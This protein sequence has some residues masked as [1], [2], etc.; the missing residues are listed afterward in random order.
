MAPLA[1]EVLLLSTALLLQ[2]ELTTISYG[3]PITTFAVSSC[4]TVMTAAT[5]AAAL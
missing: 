2:S 3:Q 1:V 5:A 4:G